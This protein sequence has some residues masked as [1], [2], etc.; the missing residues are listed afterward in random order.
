MTDRMLRAIGEPKHTRGE[1][2]ASVTYQ[3]ATQEE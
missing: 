1:L 3:P 2:P